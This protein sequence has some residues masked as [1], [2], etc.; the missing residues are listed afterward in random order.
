[1]PSIASATILSAEPDSHAQVFL[2][3][4]VQIAG[5]DRLIAAWSDLSAAAPLVQEYASRQARMPVAVLIGGDPAVQLA[6]AAPVSPAVDPLGLAELRQKPLDAVACR[7]VD[8][9]VPAESDIV[10]EGSIGPA[11]AE[12]RTPPRFSPTGRMIEERPGHVIQVTAITHRANRIFPAAV[13]GTYGNDACLRERP[14]SRLSAVLED[15]NPRVGRFRSALSG[16][17]GIWR[18]S[19][20]VRPT[21]AR[22]A[23]WRRPPGDCGR[24]LLPGCGGSRRGVNVRDA[25]QVWAAIAH[26]AHLVRD[27]WQLAVPADNIDP[28]SP[29]MSLAAEWPLTPRGS[30]CR[31]PRIA[32]G[33]VIFKSTR[34][35]LVTDRWA[36]YGLGP[37]RLEIPHATR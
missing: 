36:Q 37:E 6:A 28:T 19:P 8:L 13:P 29:G 30:F 17:Q 1:M 24:L 14:M 20:F 27:V 11:D 2:R 23:R 35:K 22:P 10:I 12:T 9:L 18:S 25:E 5:H 3:G 4:D 21:P 7:S 32:A 26:E 15:A 31:G 33:N 16:G 34:G